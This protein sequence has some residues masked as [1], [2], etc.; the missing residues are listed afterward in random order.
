MN[1][2]D[3]GFYGLGFSVLL[4]IIFVS[5]TIGVAWISA[6]SRLMSYRKK[7]AYLE[8]FARKSFK[9]LIVFELF[10]GVWGT[11]ITVF[12][13]GFFPT[14]TALATNV[15]FAPLL[16]AL[17]GIMIR[18][19][20]IGIFWYTWGK[21]HPRTH[22][23]LGLIMAI[24]GLLI[25]FGFRAIFSEITAP[26]AVAE[27]ITTGAVNAFSAF[28]SQIFWLLYFHTIF[29]ALSIGGFIVAFLSS[30]E[31]DQRGIKAGYLYGI[32]FLLLQI[33]IGALYWFSLSDKAVYMFENI[34][35]GAFL[36]VFVA[37]ITVVTLLLAFSLFGFS[38]LAYAKVLTFLSLS[39]VLLGELMNSGA[40]SPYMVVLRKEGIHYTAF[41]NFYIKIPFEAVYVILAFL[42]VSIIVFMIALFYALFR[43]YLPD[44]PE[45]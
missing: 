15:L 29:A 39:A 14:L 33:P 4:H 2:V 37:K 6:I 25:A 45:V 35:Y 38:K 44:V 20:S 32:V 28:T 31:K 3:L 18:I 27:F 21:I 13:A 24:S 12:L 10:S 23:V 42:V 5:I 30:L 11:I 17:V 34:T 22:S 41:A 9:I 40:R 19:P 1:V 7:D 36:P 43:R 16:I 8:R 26:K